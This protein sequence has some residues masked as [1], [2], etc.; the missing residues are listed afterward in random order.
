MDKPAGW[1]HDPARHALA[2]RGIPTAIP[3]QSIRARHVNIGLTRK[4]QLS[5]PFMQDI[6]FMVEEDAFEEG[7]T[8]DAAVA[9]IDDP[10]W[11]ENEAHDIALRYAGNPDENRR[12]QEFLKYMYLY[13][14]KVKK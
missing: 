6:Y 9:L 4:F 8:A 14:Q 12:I 11:I 7:G 10:K 3:A 1:R 2:A 5:Y 13:D